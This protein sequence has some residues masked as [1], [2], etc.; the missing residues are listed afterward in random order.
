MTI[1]IRYDTGRKWW[2]FKTSVAEYL[3]IFSGNVPEPTATQLS[4]FGNVIGVNVGRSGNKLGRSVRRINVSRDILVLR[5]VETTRQNC[6]ERT[7]LLQPPQGKI[8]EKN[9]VFE[10]YFIFIFVTGNR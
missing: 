10:Y 3:D 5:G 4:S 6:R 7:Q 1:R 9:I 2:K 8:D